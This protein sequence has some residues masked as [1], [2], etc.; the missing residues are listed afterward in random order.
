[1]TLGAR[2][3]AVLTYL[4]NGFVTNCPV[5]VIRLFWLK[6]LGVRLSNNV[7]VF[8][9]VTVFGAS[10]IVLGERVIIGYNVCLDGRGG[11]EIGRDSVVSSFSHLLTADHDVDSS[12]FE[13]RLAPIRIGSHCWVCTRSLVLKG[14]S[15]AD[16]SVVAANSVVT[17]S[18]PAKSIVGGNPAKFIR[19]RLCSSEYKVV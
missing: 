2:S 12:E 10:N 18:V 1:M 9:G 6:L 19:S 11:I 7:S 15:L 17:K 13:G 4:Y 16:Y 5:L 8:R 14:V 3:N